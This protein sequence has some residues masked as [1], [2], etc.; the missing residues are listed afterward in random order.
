MKTTFHKIARLLAV[1]AAFL[2]ASCSDWT[3]PESLGLHTPEIGEEYPEQYAAYLENLRSWK[4]TAH[5]AVLAAFDN[6]TAEP[7]SRAHHIASLPDSLDVVVLTAPELP[8]WQQTEMERTRRDK[9]TRFIYA[10]DHAELRADYETAGDSD[11][12]EWPAYAAERLAAALGLCDRYGY[13]GI[14]VRYSGKSTLHMTEAELAA[15]TAEQHA[16]IGPVTE[17]T[18]DNESKLF[19]FGGDPTT[20]LDQRL[21]LKADYIVVDTSA[22]TSVD[23]L[24]FAVR[25]C[26]GPQIPSGR[27]VVTVPTVVRDDPD[28]VGYYG[29]EMA[30]PLAAEWLTRPSADFTRAGLLV[31]GVERD[32]YNAGLIYKHVREAIATVNP[33]PEN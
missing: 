24:T 32:F 30:L 6:S 25:S 5:Q 22:A 21:L 23:G 16:F 29:K 9:G 20:L 3:D 18:E 11:A 14:L 8:G 7:S 27:F 4:A 2:L 10:V 1:P 19:L 31:E 12:A 33:S 13:D 15:Y 28:A 17:W 26:M